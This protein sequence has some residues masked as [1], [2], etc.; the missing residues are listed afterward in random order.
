[1]K[2]FE[3][4]KHGLTQIL[5]NKDKQNYK[6]IEILL[7]DD[8]TTSLEEI[9]NTMRTKGTVTYLWMMRNIRDA[10]L[11]RG[12]SPLWQTVFFMRIW[13]KWL[14]ENNYSPSD[15]FVIQNVYVCTELNGHMLLNT[16][17]NVIQGIFPAD[18]LRVWNCGSQG[19]EQVFRLLRS[20]T[21]MFSTVVNFSMKGVLERAHKLNFLA[22]VEASEDISFPVHSGVFFN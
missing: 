2:C 10:F 11:D 1:M 18:A 20:M 6:N 7:N 15:H 17:Y 19:C 9:D 21:P 13:R 16:V 14:H 22:S 8:V 3:K 5:E 12:I 4:T